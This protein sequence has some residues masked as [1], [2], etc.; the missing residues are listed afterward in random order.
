MWVDKQRCVYSER[1]DL[2]PE[3]FELLVR[4]AMERRR[5]ATSETMFELWERDQATI[6]QFLIA[7]KGL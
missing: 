7:S 2:T 5:I 3:G 1:T 4:L 6:A